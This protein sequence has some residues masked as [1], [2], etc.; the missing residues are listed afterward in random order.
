M[1]IPPQAKDWTVSQSSSEVAP[2][3]SEELFSSESEESTG[4]DLNPYTSLRTHAQRFNI[5]FSYRMSNP[6]STFCATI[7]LNM[8]A[9]PV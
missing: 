1:D 5:S 4:E 6:Y 7:N 9:T 8:S 3:E 2:G